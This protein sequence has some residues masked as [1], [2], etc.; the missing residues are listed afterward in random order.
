LYSCL[1]D[2]IDIGL[3]GSTH[4]GMKTQWIGIEL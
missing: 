4:Q 1:E 3:Q 2:T